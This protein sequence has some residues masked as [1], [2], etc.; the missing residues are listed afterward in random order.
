MAFAE[1]WN[2]VPVTGRYLEIDGTPA[3]GYLTFK[4]SPVRMTDAKAL[5][6][7][8][9][10]EYFVQLGGD[11]SFSIKLP[12]TDDPDITPF[13][14]TYEVA[15]HF[16]DGTNNTWNVEIPIIYADMGVDISTLTPVANNPGIPV[17]ITRE[18]FDALAMQVEMLLGTVYGGSAGTQYAGPGLDGGG[19]EGV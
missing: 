10:S 3:V 8:L 6:T 9:Q 12:A 15:E 4:P 1:N 17:T 7:V 19:V 11:G 18:E 16:E 5:V 14:F 13:D 2:L